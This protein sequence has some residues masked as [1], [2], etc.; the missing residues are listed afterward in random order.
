MR[1]ECP[2]FSRTKL[3]A[4]D[5]TSHVFCSD[6]LSSFK[7]LIKIEDSHIHACILMEKLLF[8]KLS[9]PMAELGPQLVQLT[10]LNPLSHQGLGY[11]LQS[12]ETQ[13]S[14]SIK[15]P[16]GANISRSPHLGGKTSQDHPASD[17]LSGYI[18]W[19]R[20]VFHMAIV[21]LFK[22]HLKTITENYGIRFDPLNL[23]KLQKR[24]DTKI[25]SIHLLHTYHTKNCTY[26]FVLHQSQDVI[27][28][29]FSFH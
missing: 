6:H 17:M 4:K 15:T 8:P 3:G 20:G 7:A 24:S 27:G 22:Y 1:S 29:P 23:S 13:A 14:W 2:R 18:K 10:R 25:P 21:K 16:R 12:L 19:S 11:L 5:N 9:G 26:T 28:L